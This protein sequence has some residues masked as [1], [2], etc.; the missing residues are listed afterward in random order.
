MGSLIQ[1]PK[2]A[3]LKALASE[4]SRLKERID[5]LEDLRDL[6]AAEQVAGGRPGIPWEQ[7]KKLLELDDETPSGHAVKKTVKRTRQ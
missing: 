2:E 5:D 7:A 3:T 6:L 1:R 4:V